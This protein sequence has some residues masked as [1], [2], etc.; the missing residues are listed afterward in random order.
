VTLVEL[1]LQSSISEET[2]EETDLDEKRQVNVEFKEEMLAVEE[3]LTNL[4]LIKNEVKVYLHLACNGP[5]KA[6]DICQSITL[7]RTEIYRLLR[8]LEKRGLICIT[9]GKP[10]QFTAVPLEEAI[11][12][13][14]QTQRIKIDRL[15]REKNSLVKLWISIPQQRAPNPKKVLFQ[16]LEGQQQILLKA[17]DLLEKATSEFKIFAPDSYLA[18]FYYGGFTDKLRKKEPQL[19]ISL[20]VEKSQKALY[21]AEQIQWPTH[22]LWF[23][24]A[25]NL[26]CFIVSDEKELL[27]AFYESE[28]TDASGYRK[29]LRNAA[30]WT[31][32]EA[33]V[34]TFTLLSSKMLESPRPLDVL[35]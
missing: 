1:A 12:L 2:F 29:K 4:G 17:N 13:L 14:V 22:K 23:V 21:F 5:T 11:D 32:N 35:S 9:L 10:V 25:K 16:K 3:A 27:V 28:K 34:Q 26:P 20:I 19:G 33:V 24:D 18:D 8:H 6:R 31:N 30:I 7:H 15:E